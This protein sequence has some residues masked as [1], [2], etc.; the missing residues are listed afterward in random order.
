MNEGR[1]TGSCHVS[2]GRPVRTEANREGRDR[3]I[4]ERL[5]ANKRK[6]PGPSTTTERRTDHRRNDV[7]AQRDEAETAR[8]LPISAPG[9]L[10]L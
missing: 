2:S 8:K 4:N 3:T 10:W 1:E 5:T 7:A 9:P 6:W